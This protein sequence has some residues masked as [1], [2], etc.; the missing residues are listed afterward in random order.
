MLGHS[1]P[2]GRLPSLGGGGDFKTQEHHP[3]VLSWVEKSYSS[4]QGVGRQGVG[5]QG[6]A[7]QGVGREGVGGSGKGRGGRGFDR[8]VGLGWAGR[9]C[10]RKGGTHSS[11]EKAH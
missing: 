1:L 7:R 4:S 3:E 2:S 10:P 8:Q 9:R 5:R 6:A 11:S